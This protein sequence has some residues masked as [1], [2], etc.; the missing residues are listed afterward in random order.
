ML[1]CA[2]LRVSLSKPGLAGADYCLGAIRY[3][4]LGEDA[5]NVVAY[6]FGAKVQAGGDSVIRLYPETAKSL[7]Q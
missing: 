6:R 1:C 2:G 7:R 4:K 3:L 5:R